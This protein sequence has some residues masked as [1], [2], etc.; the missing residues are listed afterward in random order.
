MRTTLKRGVGRGAEFNGNGY[1]VFPPGPV[2]AIVR[3]S[4]PPPPG[5][6][7][8]SVLRRIL[9]AML[10]AVLALVIGGAGGAYLWF[11]QSVNAVRAHSTDVKVAQRQLD[12]TLPGEAAIALALGYDARAGIHGFGPSDSR[13]DTVMLLRADPQTKTIS[14]LSFPRDLIVPIYCPGHAVVDDRINSAYTRCGSKGTLDT[15]KHLTGLPINY[16]IT[17]NFHGFKEVVDQLGGV[18]MDVDRRYYNRNTG[19]AATDF[20]NINLQPGYQQLGGGSALDFVRYRHTDSDL[21]RLAR[22]QEFVKAFKEQVSQHFDPLNLPKIV[23]AITHN[24]EVGS[25]SN[26]DV[27]TVLRYALFAATLPGGHLIQVRIN[28]ITGYGEL[29]APTGSIQS[30]VSSFENPDV[31]VAKVAN[32][33]ALGEKL[34]TS[35]PPPQQTNVTVLNGNGIPGSAANATYLLRGRGYV[36]LLPPNGAPADA[37]LQNYFHTQIYFNRIVPRSRAAAV[38]L[39]KLLQPADVRPLPADPRLRALDPGAILL[40]VLGQTFHDALSAAPPAAV[41]VRQPAVVRYDGAPGLELLRPLAKRVPFPLEVPT[42]LE[43]NSYP[44]TC[45]GDVPARFYWITKGQKAI[46]LVFRTGGNEYWGIEETSWTDAPILGDRSFRH[47]LGGREFDLYYSGPHLHM[48]VLRTHGA[49]Y[50][51]VNTLLDSLSNETM[52]A[53]AKGLKPLTAVK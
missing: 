37:P 53:I 32:A 15:V 1:S 21:Y 6:S 19:S 7:G 4:Q 30:A 23:S 20:A 11:H 28:D 25:K 29:S 39:Q 5:R 46:R 3:Y 44:D 52:I 8:L 9:L 18:W 50:W 27:G 45:C 47:D 40:V 10:L 42:I 14:M 36:T 43:R 49:S 16:L 17:V 34:K 2:S 31:Q 22:Q 33:T 51:V 12:V 13:S 48:A 41:P 24:L 35:A 26:F 38:V